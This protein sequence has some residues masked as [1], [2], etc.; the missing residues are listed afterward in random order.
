M[1]D[2]AMLTGDALIMA[3]AL[4]RFALVWVVLGL[5]VVAKLIWRE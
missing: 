2:P 4:W 3:G 1:T 5:A